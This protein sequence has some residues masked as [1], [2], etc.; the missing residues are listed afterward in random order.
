MDKFFV[1]QRIR[2]R[3]NAS[4]TISY[5]G[6]IEG[7]ANPFC[8]VT[9]DYPVGKYDGE[10]L[11]KRYFTCPVGHGAFVREKALVPC[12]AL[13]DLVREKYQNKSRIDGMDQ[14]FVTDGFTETKVQFFGQEKIE[15]RQ[16][17]ISELTEIGFQGELVG[18]L[19]DSAIFAELTSLKSLD[20]SFTL[21]NDPWILLEILRDIPSLEEIYANGCGVHWE[22]LLAADEQTSARRQVLF[23]ALEAR[24]PF[25]IFTNSH[26]KYA[27]FTAPFANT[28]AM[29]S[30]LSIPNIYSL[31]CDFWHIGTSLFTRDILTDQARTAY[32]SVRTLTDLSIACSLAT[33][34]LALLFVAIARGLPCLESLSLLTELDEV[35]CTSIPDY[36]L[37]LCRIRT[38]SQMASATTCL[39]LSEAA[40]ADYYSRLRPDELFGEVVLP[41][42]NNML[43]SLVLT[44]ISISVNCLRL[45]HAVY[46]Q[47]VSVKYSTINADYDIPS[48]DYD[49]VVI[50]LLSPC[51]K[52]LNSAP[53]KENIVGFQRYYLTKWIE[54]AKKLPSELLLASWSSSPE[55]HWL[56]RAHDVELPE[57]LSRDLMSIFPDIQENFAGNI[58]VAAEDEASKH[59]CIMRYNNQL[60][61]INFMNGPHESSI[62]LPRGTPVWRLKAI[63]YSTHH[64]DVENGVIASASR[65]HGERLSKISAFSKLGDIIA[66][67]ECNVYV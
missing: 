41:V 17:N 22:R 56:V 37:P 11:G 20:L 32:P 9:W 62:F 24:R 54:R 30:L 57:K 45:I 29:R 5:L 3:D 31:H 49:A 53:L 46:P 33:D 36:L 55:V 6:P 38:S 60:V 64:L 7:Q 28:E 23:Q 8:G 50:T 34:Q 21:L 40:V 18:V 66:D 65:Y 52:I 48:K 25:A 12:V 59:V 61:K 44:G 19:G 42:A 13:S 2:G 67:P 26:K 43:K 47:I 14:M 58:S 27:G 16:R 1:G 15:T 63:F 4:G 10:Y 35:Q 51:I 39:P